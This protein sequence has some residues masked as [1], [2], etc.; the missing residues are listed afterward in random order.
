MR[1]AATFTWYACTLTYVLRPSYDRTVNDI[2]ME[3][4]IMCYGCKTAAARR[5]IGE[6]YM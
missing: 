2:I 3:M 5:I 6:R 4:L 1:V